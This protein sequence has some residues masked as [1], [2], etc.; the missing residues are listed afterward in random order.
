MRNRH[1]HAGLVSEEMADLSI[2]VS[3]PLSLRVHAETVLEVQSG[4][5]VSGHWLAVMG[6]LHLPELRA[7]I[8][9]FAREGD[10]NGNGHAGALRAT[11]VVIPRNFTMTVPVQRFA[12]PELDRSEV[13]ASTHAPN[14]DPPWAERY[15]GKLDGELLTFDQYITVEPILD[16]TFSRCEGRNGGGAEME[17]AGELRFDRPSPM[18]LQFRHPRQSAAPVSTS[19]GHQAMLM[20]AGASAVIPRQILPRMTGSNALKCVRVIEAGGR[21]VGLDQP[22]SGVA[23]RAS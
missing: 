9:F 5:L 14:Q 21:V 1:V 20:L 12:L 3:T 6:T 8:E 17:F 4:D 16:A 11:A 15:A 19:D 22:L 23:R 2:R 18:R 13:W 7:E 10:A